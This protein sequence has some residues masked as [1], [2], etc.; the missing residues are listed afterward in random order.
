MDEN[1]N[2]NF[3]RGGVKKP[4]KNI[5]PNTK[6]RD[7]VREALELFNLSTEDITTKT[8]TIYDGIK[9]LNSDDN[10]DKTV[11]DKGIEDSANMNIFKTTEIIL[12]KFIFHYQEN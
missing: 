8:Y 12:G 2:L 5:D 1:I 4:L 6:I 10:L 3:I 11:Y 9:I 7:I